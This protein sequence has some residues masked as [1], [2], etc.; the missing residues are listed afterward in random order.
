M[1]FALSNIPD[2]NDGYSE[3]D[4]DYYEEVQEKI[5]NTTR[6]LYEREKSLKDNSNGISGIE[7]KIIEEM[8]QQEKREEVLFDK[9]FSNAKAKNP[10][11]QTLCDKTKTSNTN[12]DL[13]GTKKISD[14]TTVEF[15]TALLYDRL[16]LS[17]GQVKQKSTWSD[18]DIFALIISSDEMYYAL[19]SNFSSE[20]FT[21]TQALKGT[22]YEKTIDTM[23]TNITVEALQA[24]YEKFQDNLWQ[25]G[26]F[27][28]QDELKK[29]VD[30]LLKKYLKTS[31]KSSF[32]IISN[33]KLKKVVTAETF[34]QNLRNSIREVLDHYNIDKYELTNEGSNGKQGTTILRV[35]STGQK[36]AG[37]NLLYKDQYGKKI[38][39]NEYIVAT[40]QTLYNTIKNTISKYQILTIGYQ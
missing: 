12:F 6:Y 16:S 37:S 25:I 14:M 20:I 2:T 33:W 22:K 35:Y 17:S 23:G 29:A 7:K 21:R 27:V 5:V 11:Y 9:I 34:S 28:M 15:W 32:K 31:K 19:K 10:H 39:G 13:S 26:N 3:Q 38:E 8:K 24:F 30:T 40:F 18:R 36:Q 4:L 1:Y